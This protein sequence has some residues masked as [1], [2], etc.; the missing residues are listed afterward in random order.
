VKGKGIPHVEGDLSWHH[1]SRVTEEEIE[2]L[3]TGIEEAT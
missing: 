1:K 3:Y 2:A